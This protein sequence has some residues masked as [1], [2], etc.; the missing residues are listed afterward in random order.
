MI[1]IIVSRCD[2]NLITEWLEK[3]KFIDDIDLIEGAT[4]DINPY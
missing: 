4:N 3:I 1:F 2:S